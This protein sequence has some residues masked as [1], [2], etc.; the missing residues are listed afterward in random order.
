MYGHSINHFQNQLFLFGGTS[1]F[2]FFKELFKYD[3]LTNTW[4][5]L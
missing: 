2:E 3:L 4:Q 5:K 1:G